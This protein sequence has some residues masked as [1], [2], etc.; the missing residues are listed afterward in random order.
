LF[1]FACFV[2]FFFFLSGGCIFGARQPC[3]LTVRPFVYMQKEDVPNVARDD[4]AEA[5]YNEFNRIQL[6]TQSCVPTLS[7]HF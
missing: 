7:L 1:R 2:L 6:T 5:L 3:R 4:K